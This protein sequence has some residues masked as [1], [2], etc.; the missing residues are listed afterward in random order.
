MD[1]A[2]VHVQRRS[3]DFQAGQAKIAAHPY[4]IRD[5]DIRSGRALEE[6]LG[7]FEEQRVRDA[8]SFSWARRRI[9]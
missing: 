7:D 3:T 5:V 1:E 4:R 9:P 6:A 8:P 2:R